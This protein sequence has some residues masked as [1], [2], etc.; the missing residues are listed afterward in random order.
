MLNKT[1]CNAILLLSLFVSNVFTFEMRLNTLYLTAAESSAINFTFDAYGLNYDTV[2]LPATE[3]KLEEGKV[4]L[5]NAIVVEEATKEMLQGILDQIVQYQK[6]YKVRVAYLNCEPSIRAGMSS[7][8][9]TTEK[10][11][12]RLTPEGLELAKKYQMNGENVDFAVPCF[13]VDGDF[14]HYNVNIEDQ[15]IVPLLKYNDT[16][17]YAGA[18]V[19]RHDIE[20]IHFFTGNSNVLLTYFNSH[21]WIPWI[22][23]G[24]IDGYRRLNFGI[25]I[26]DFFISNPFN[27]TV[28]TEFRTSIQDMKN[29]AQWQKDI[30]TRMPKGSQFKIELAMNGMYVLYTAKHKTDITQSYEHHPKEYGYVKPLEEEGTHKWPDVIDSDWDDSVLRSGDKLYDYFARN[31]EAQD[32]FY[33]LTHTFSHQNL[34]Y[35]SF[36]DADMEIALNVKMADEPYLGMYKRECYSPQ[37]IVCPEI[38]GLHNGHTLQAFEKNHVHFAVGDTSRPDLASGNPYLPVITNQTFANFD[39]FVIIPRQPTGMFWDCSTAEQILTLNEERT[40]KVIDW[41]THVRRDIETNVVN[42][43]KMRHDPYMFHE[44]NLRNEDFE[45]SE[46]NGVKGKFGLVQQWVEHMVVEIRKYMEWPLITKK[47]DDLGQSFVTRLGKNQCKPVYT[48]TIEDDSLILKEITVSATTGSCTVPLL[49]IRNTSFNQKSVDTVE[50]YGDEPETAW[51]EVSD[52]SPKTVLFNQDI[53]WN[54]DSFTPGIRPK[55]VNRDIVDSA[56]SSPSFFTTT[57]SVGQLFV[58]AVASMMVMVSL[59]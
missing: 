56:S 23:Y 17:T 36:H 49:A 20:S 24:I 26:D 33:W 11:F 40:G 31:P 37:S 52:A 15:G 45:E 41:D 34:N 9:K 8:P 39:G 10:K 50:Q 27:F 44:G 53:K 7:E 29:L 28:G 30:L 51:I 21:L 54:D 47:M 6:K 43:V 4:A 22:N 1:I 5:Y 19:Q 59:F 48:M 38:S 46:I 35:A 18:I 12:V 14:Y 55:G 25:Q 2:R 32:H 13:E 57:L 58:M 42:F 3:L 16:D